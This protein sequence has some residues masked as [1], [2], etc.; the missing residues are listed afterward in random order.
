MLRSNQKGVSLSRFDDSNTKHADVCMDGETR[1]HADFN[2][3]ENRG[4][5]IRA[6]ACHFKVGHNPRRMWATRAIWL[7]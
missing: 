5:E 7:G 3:N 6:V 1:F 2:L 4:D